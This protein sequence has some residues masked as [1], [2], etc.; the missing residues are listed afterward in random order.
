MRNDKVLDMCLS[1][2]SKDKY[3]D[4]EEIIDIDNDIIKFLCN[5]EIGIIFLNEKLEIKRYIN[6]ITKYISVSDKYIGKSIKNVSTRLKNVELY[7]LCKKVIETGE[8]QEKKV[9]TDKGEYFILKI[10]PNFK[11]NMKVKGVIITLNDISQ[12]VEVYG[13]LEKLA[14]AVKQSPSEIIIIDIDTK[15]E[16]VNGAF[17]KITGYDF[18]EVYGKNIF[19]V[20][21]NNS[22][23]EEVDHIHFIIKNGQTW[24]KQIVSKKKNGEL[25]IEK[26]IIS[27]ITSSDGNIK[28]FLVIMEDISKQ[29]KD[30]EKILFLAYHDTLTGLYNRSKIEEL[31]Y[32][33]LKFDEKKNI[34]LL[35]LDIDRFKMIN[36]TLGHDVGDRLLQLVAQKIRCIINKNGIVS[37]M[38]GDEFAILLT[39]NVTEK[40]VVKIARKIIEDIKKGFKVNDFN[41]NITMSIGIAIYPYSGKD[42]K[43]LLKNAD[44]S[45]YKAKEEGRDRY[46]IYYP[47]MES[48]MLKNMLIEN[49]LN[50][51]LEDN[52][53]T[54]YYQPQ[55][56]IKT[57]KIVGAEALLRWN[58]SEL[59]IVSP[60]EFIPIAEETGIIKKLGLW[61]LK[62]VCLQNMKWRKKGL[63]QL[64][65]SVNVSV[66]QLKDVHFINKLKQILKDTQMNTEFLELEI[67]ETSTLNNLE[68]VIKALNGIREM[69]IDIALDDFGTGYS[70]MSYLKK[71]PINTLK[72]DKS[73]VDGVNEKSVDEAIVRAVIV[74]AKAL[75]LKVVAEGVEKEGQFRFLDKENCDIIQGYLFSKPVLSEEIERM[76][77][78]EYL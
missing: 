56:D 32:K 31:F 73:L 72:I 51:A 77:K 11:S 33:N 57:R 19:D 39:E 7:S 15:I 54:I 1:V 46:K 76:L 10:L 30:E 43:T 64:K 55:V 53:F 66:Q 71:Y 21:F 29:K 37:R 50:K 68:F 47:Y 12:L 35:F 48:K 17:T 2:I 8:K 41:I 52:E 5:S 6:G 69:G 65:I 49:S 59:G 20:K 3:E 40:S 58:S 24:K 9:H 4:I 22:T 14:C 26:V 75:K 78:K 34:A 13:E 44:I 74:M 36:D 42:F 18:E 28:N 70:S 27:P 62:Q 25:Y 38:G 67:T 61:V 63:K 23:N 45:M 16:Y 60:S